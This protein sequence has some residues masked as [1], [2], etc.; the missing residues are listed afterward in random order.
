MILVQGTKSWNALKKLHEDKMPDYLSYSQANTP[1][2]HIS[3]CLSDYTTY[4]KL[5]KGNHEILSSKKVAAVIKSFSYGFAHDFRNWLGTTT[6]FAQL[7]NLIRVCHIGIVE[8]L[9]LLP[10]F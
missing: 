8:L 3:K 5:H 6:T 7:L 2:R 9:F 10:F 4:I 1:P